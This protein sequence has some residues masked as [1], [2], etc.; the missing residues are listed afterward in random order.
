MSHSGNHFSDLKLFYLLILWITCPLFTWGQASPFVHHSEIGLLT[1][2]DDFGTR[3]N[4]TFQ[5][6]NGVRFHPHHEF[7]FVT[8]IDQYGPL[9]LVPI[10]MGWRGVLNPESQIALYASFD[11]GY[12][13]TLF[14]KK[15]ITEWNEHRWHEGGLLYQPAFGLRFKNRKDRFWTL[16]L[17]FKK[18]VNYQY[19]GMPIMGNGLNSPN[20]RKPEDWNYISRDKI[21]FNNLV[22]RIGFQF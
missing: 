18:Q 2:H 11:L 7:G 21:T 12:G 22:Y 15:Q 5:T 17:G 6:F 16:S 14:E 3:V 9:S 13:S 1:G 10:A 19:S 20:P 8:G 4:F